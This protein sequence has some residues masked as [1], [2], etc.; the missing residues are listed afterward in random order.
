MVS[1]NGLKYYVMQ[2]VCV[3]WRLKLQHSFCHGHI[4]ALGWSQL[5]PFHVQVSSATC[6]NIWWPRCSEPSTIHHRARQSPLSRS[7]SFAF[8]ISNC[9]SWEEITNWAYFA[10]LHRWNMRSGKRRARPNERS[11]ERDS[12]NTSGKAPSKIGDIKDIA[13][14][15]PIRKIHE[16]W[17]FV[18]LKCYVSFQER[19]RLP[20][21]HP[22]QTTS[23]PQVLFER[24]KQHFHLRRKSNQRK[25]SLPRNERL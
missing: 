2:P 20:R 11:P 4:N 8:A 6:F 22:S 24:K 12:E 13:Q 10:G 7:V 19:N 25:S 15:K 9:S 1:D 14:S 3:G 17:C 18:Q 23:S 21:S 5:W 16:A